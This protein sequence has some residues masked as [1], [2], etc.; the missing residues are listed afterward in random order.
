MRQHSINTPS[1]PFIGTDNVDV[2]TMAY[3]FAIE[4]HV[5]FQQDEEGTKTMFAR[6]RR[7]REHYNCCV[8]EDAA[9]PTGSFFDENES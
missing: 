4:E 1:T 6:E 9:M 2:E 3:S 8:A 7:S 5:E